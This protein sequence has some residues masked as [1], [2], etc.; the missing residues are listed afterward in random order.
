M[1]IRLTLSFWSFVSVVCSFVA[2]VCALMILASE[3]ALIFRTRSDL[4]AS[5]PPWAAFTG[6]ATKS[7]APHS[8]ARIVVSVPF[9]VRPETM[10]TGIGRSF[11][12]FPRKVRPSIFGISTSSVMT[13]GLRSLIICRARNG[14]GAA[15]TTLISGSESRMEANILRIT[16]ESSTITTRIFRAIEI[17]VEQLCIAC[18]IVDL[19]LFSEGHF[20]LE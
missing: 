9:L 15:P 4:K 17:L 5:R 19:N 14:S 12:I 7:T 18:I 6:F 3:A 1:P 20:F 11:M 10:I 13:S 16:A 8:N 2:F